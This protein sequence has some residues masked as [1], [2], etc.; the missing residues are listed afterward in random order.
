MTREIRIESEPIKEN[1]IVCGFCGP[2]SI[3]SWDVMLD[4]GEQVYVCYKDYLALRNVELILYERRIG[5][6][7]WE[8]VSELRECLNK[9]EYE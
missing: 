3:A 8:E 7:V 5:E 2:G 6:M 4:D 9:M 1:E